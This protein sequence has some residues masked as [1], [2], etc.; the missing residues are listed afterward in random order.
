MLDLFVLTFNR[1]HFLKDTIEN[2]LCQTFKDY[3]LTVLDNGSTDNTKEMVALFG[4]KVKY[5]GANK[6]YGATWNFQRAI[7]TANKK[8][9]MMFHDEDMLYPGYLEYAVE[10]LEQDYSR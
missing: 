2:L 7:D 3:E 1:A 4:E 5:I 8:Y 6:N 9:T 10:L